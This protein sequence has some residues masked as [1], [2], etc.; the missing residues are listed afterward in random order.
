MVAVRVFSPA[1]PDHD[2]HLWMAGLGRSQASKEAEILVLRHGVWPRRTM[3]SMR[4]RTGTLFGV[5][6]G[7]YCWL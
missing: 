3:P 4:S 5:F 7:I 2:P 1:V 6:A